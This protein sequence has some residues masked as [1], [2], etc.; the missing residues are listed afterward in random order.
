MKCPFNKGIRM[1]IGVDQ[2]G[3][4]WCGLGEVTTVV[5]P[6][7]SFLRLTL[8]RARASES[9]LVSCCR[10]S[11]LRWEDSPEMESVDLLSWLKLVYSS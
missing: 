3:E 1:H 7:Y 10:N 9:Y 11:M 6:T 5:A 2:V 8:R 4:R